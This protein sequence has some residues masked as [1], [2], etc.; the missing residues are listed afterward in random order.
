MWRFR[1]NPMSK[2][3]TLAA[4]KN[5]ERNALLGEERAIDV[6]MLAA[7]S[8]LRNINIYHFTATVTLG[9]HGYGQCS[10]GQIRK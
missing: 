4:W 3:L 7:V 2:R 1:E 5:E 10:E 8:G 9:F 6:R